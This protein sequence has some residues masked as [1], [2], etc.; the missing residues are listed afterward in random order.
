MRNLVRPVAV[1][2][3]LGSIAV[4][5]KK[6]PY[7]GRTQFNVVPEQTMNALG[8][9]TYEEML[10][11]LR[12]VRGN[13]DARL[14]DNVGERIAAQ[15]DKPSYEWDTSLILEDQVNAWALPGG[16]IGFYTGILPV[17][18]TEAGM[19]FVMGHEVG[20]SLAQHGAERL[21][22]QLS[23]LGGLTV[24]DAYLG[25][26]GDVSPEVRQAIVGALGIGATVGVVLPF[27][28]AHESEADVIGMMLMAEAG[29]PPSEA[30]PIWQRMEQASE[31]NRPP[32]FL[33]TH[34]SPAKRTENMREWLPKAQK[35]YQR[36]KL[37]YDTTVAR[38]TGDQYDA[39]DR[40][41]PTR[42]QTMTRPGR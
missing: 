31:G 7:T 37:P 34:P 25:G 35:R 39:P 40:K 11:Q 19:S 28:R 26:R 15:A 21:T 16:Y 4:A 41:E 38:W 13:E 42:G 9:R 36:N 12:V 24:L 1:L 14:L 2:V 33:A 30:I 27:S 18:K 8:E 23:L 20:H 6:V 3:A 10:S 5:C 17:L 32:T 22:Q 29:Y